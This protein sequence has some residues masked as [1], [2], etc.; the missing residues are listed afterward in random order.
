[1][2]LLLPL[3]RGAAGLAV[4]SAAALAAACADSTVAPTAAG[5]RA[6]SFHVSNTP[7]TTVCKVGPSGN[8]QFQISIWPDRFVAPTNLSGT[9]LVANPFSLGA[10]QC[11]DI[12]KGG[13]LMD[14]IHISEINLPAGVT[15]EKIVVQQNGGDCALLA[16][17]CPVTLTGVSVASLEVFEG[18]SYTVTF[19]NKGDTPPPPPPGGQGCTPGFWKNSTG[20]WVGYAP[21]QDFDAVFGVNAFDPNRTLLAALG[22]NGGGVDALARHATAGLLAAAHPDVNYNLTSTQII[23]MVKAALAPGGDIEGTKN[24]LAAFNEQGCPLAN[25]DSF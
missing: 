22:S 4:L 13:A 12:F 14:G 23:A 17:F 6:P 25:D 8:Y 5:P 19:Y 20:S 11:V 15:L 18:K 7:N 10:G 3:R 21:S 9:V 1:M 24:K 16:E 2:A